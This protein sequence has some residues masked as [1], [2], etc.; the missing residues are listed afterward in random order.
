[1]EQQKI[2]YFGYGTT[3]ELEMMKAITGK[4]NLIGKQAILKGYSLYIQKLDQISDEIFP[5]SLEP[6][7]A[8]QILRNNWGENFTSY[9]MK[10]DENKEVKGIVW[11]LDELD[12]ELLKNWELNEYGWFKDLKT[13][14]TLE[15]GEIIDVITGELGDGQEID[16]EVKDVDYQSYLIEKDRLLK[17]AEEVRKLYL[18]SLRTK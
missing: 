5:N 4:E 9:T 10:S 6:I 3:R 17:R 18:E 8:R 11:E 12:F 16:H 1:M 14:V 7:S 15:N 13:K 2:L